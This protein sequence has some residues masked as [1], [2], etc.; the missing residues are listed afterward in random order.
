MNLMFIANQLTN[1]Q[2]KPNSC[3]PLTQLPAYSKDFLWELPKSVLKKYLMVEIVYLTD[4]FWKN[5]HDWKTLQK[6]INSFEK[7][8]CG[9]TVK[10][11]TTT[12][13]KTKQLP[14]LGHQKSDQKSKK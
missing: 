8:S 14:F 7:K 13:T 6:I 2:V 9:T 3:Y 11:I 1:V 12:L 5:G 4:I 10:I